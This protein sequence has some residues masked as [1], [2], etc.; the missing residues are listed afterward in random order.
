MGEITNRDKRRLPIGAEVL[1]GAGVNF[2]IWAPDTSRAAVGITRDPNDNEE[3]IIALHDEGNGYFSA[4][5]NFASEGMLYR[6]I[7]DEDERIIPDPASRYQPRGPKWLSQIVDPRKFKWSD[8][9][10]KGPQDTT[11]ILYQMHIGT[12]TKEGTWKAATPELSELAHMGITAVLIMPV[13]DFNGSFGWGYDA[14]CPFAPTRL[15]GTPDDFREFVNEA[16]RYEIAVILDVVYNHLGP[17]FEYFKKFS[18]DYFTSKYKSSWS[19]AISYDGTRSGPVREFFVS[20]AAYWVDEFHLDGI[21]LDATQEIYD[22]SSYHIISEIT[23]RIKDASQN[24]NLLIIAENEPQDIAYVKGKGIDLMLNDDFH[25]TAMV[26]LTGRK[27]GYYSDYSGTPQELISTSKYGYLYQGQH[28]Y[29]KRGVKGTPSLSFENHF[30]SFLQN[31]DQIANSCRGY[32]IERMS[33]PGRLR[34]IST[35][36]L[37]GPQTPLLFQGQEFAASTPFYFF[38]DYEGEEERA[39]AHGRQDYLSIFPSIAA[40]EGPL[41]PDPATLECFE[42]CKLNLR[43][44]SLHG[45]WYRFHCDMIQIRKEDPIFKDHN[46]ERIDGALLSAEAFVIRYFGADNTGDRL[47]IINMGKDAHIQT[48]PEPLTAP[49]SGKKWTQVCYSE[50]PV[51][52]GNGAQPLYN[53]GTWSICGQAAYYLKSE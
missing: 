34:A 6:V 35:L 52:G 51:F 48:S 13:G 22:S 18:P 30:I 28:S 19:E 39:V 27:E 26:A 46:R 29:F 42:D 33:S 10:W 24:R 4:D 17:G 47:L 2:R 40:V 9:T 20:N 50:D 3:A 7:L 8:D 37:L 16:H 38:A 31:H 5:A 11:N 32:R 12:F 36:M 49:P 53:K 14:V 1:D 23:S 41:V 45:E 44:R 21:R 15:Y 25:H 43:E